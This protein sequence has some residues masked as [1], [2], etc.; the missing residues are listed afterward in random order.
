LSDTDPN[1][2]GAA[3]RAVLGDAL[4][5]LYSAAIRVAVRLGIA[6]NL[7]DGP[8]TP[9]QLAELTG[10]NAGHLRRILRFLATRGVFREDE[11]G[12]YHLT[13]AANFL[14][15]DSPV[16]IRSMVLL[17]TDPKI[18]WEPAG[19]LEETVRAGTTVFN[20]INGM[21][22]FDFL[23]A[24]EESGDVFHTGIADLS[25]VE[26]GSIAE[27]FQFP[28]TGTVVDVAGG[29]GGM[30]HAILTRNPGLR[31]VLYEQEDLLKQLRLDDAAIAGRWETVAGNFFSDVPPSGDIYLL[32]RVLHDWS[33]EDC[34][35]I[36]K[37]CRAAMSETSRLLVID[38]VIPTGDDPHPGKLY[39]VAMMTNFD[40]KE[41]TAAE[42][43]ELFAKAGLKALRIIPTP[44]TLSIIETVIT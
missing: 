11:T 36:L 33:D 6:D 8:K 4:G 10:S 41:R 26:Q 7:A 21:P 30:L 39:D 9:E 43:D 29:P 20:K 23:A 18:Y 40:G 35:R 44:G 27:S 15:V 5:Y 14:R 28:E 17:L 37:T 42:F 22:L 2:V 3:V 32:K 31:G 25:A 12:A 34:L 13:T 19:R 16:P 1:D 38:A 24:D